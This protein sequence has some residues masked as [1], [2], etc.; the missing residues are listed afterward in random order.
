MKKNAIHEHFLITEIICIMFLLYCELFQFSIRSFYFLFLLL[1][2]TASLEQG[3][4]LENTLPLSVILRI[5][6]QYYM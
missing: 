3:R 5:V 4:P 6:S 1:F 2:L